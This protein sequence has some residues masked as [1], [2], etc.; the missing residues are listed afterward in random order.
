[1]VT[2]GGKVCIIAG[3]LVRMGA[4]IVA[5]NVLIKIFGF[6]AGIAV[7]V[8]GMRMKPIESNTTTHKYTPL[9]HLNPNYYDPNGHYAKGPDGWNIKKDKDSKG[10]I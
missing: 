5:E 3:I 9:T 4:V 1:M 6:A 10:A 7:M 2:T 8:Q